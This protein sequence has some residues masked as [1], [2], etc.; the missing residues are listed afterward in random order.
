MDATW[1]PH[2]HAKH[3]SPPHRQ[4]RKSEAFLLIQLTAIAQNGSCH[5]QPNI[6]ITETSGT[7]KTTTTASLAM[8]TEVRHINVGDFANEENLMNDWDDTFDC[9]YIKKT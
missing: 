8:V 5:K 9:Y 3:T 6:L 7:R 1:M 4:L 2:E